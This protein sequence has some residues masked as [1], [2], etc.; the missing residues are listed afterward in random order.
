MSDSTWRLDGSRLP[1]RVD[2]DIPAEI[3]ELMEE[4]SVRSGRSVR[5]L[6]EELIHRSPLR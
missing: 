1:Q 6:V 3:Y 2:L 5:D 4:R